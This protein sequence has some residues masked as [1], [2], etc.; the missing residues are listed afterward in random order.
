MTSGELIENIMFYVNFRGK[1]LNVEKKH[2]RLMN[3]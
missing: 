2:L 1:Y 3:V